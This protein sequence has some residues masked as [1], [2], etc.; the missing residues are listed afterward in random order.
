MNTDTGNRQGENE[1]DIRRALPDDVPGLVDS[2]A[3]LFAEDGATRDRLR[4]PQ[5]PQDHGRPWIDGLLASPDALV[6]VAAERDGTVV[7]HLIGYFN[8]SSPMWTGARTELISTY[9]SATHRGQGIGGRFV[10]DFLAWSR[11][12]GAERFHVSA[13]AANEDA[14]RF[15]RRHGFAPLSIELAADA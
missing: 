10:A 13:Y 11:D 2:S 14:I 5:W 7:G 1:I 12:R 6:L 3:G 8:A 4:N 9:V 15:Y